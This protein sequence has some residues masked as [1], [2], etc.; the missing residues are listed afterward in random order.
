MI[1]YQKFKK[2]T[3]Y[4]LLFFIFL[5]KSVFNFLKIYT[6]DYLGISSIQGVFDLKLFEIKKSLLPSLILTLVI[7]ILEKF[8]N[9]DNF[10]N[11][12]IVNKY[13]GLKQI[14]KIN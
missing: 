9:I 14:Q 7:F 6:E 12:L 3:L 1:D 11:T 13:T 4:I 2:P 8:V 5:S 10:L